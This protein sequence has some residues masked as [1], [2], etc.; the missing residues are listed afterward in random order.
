MKPEMTLVLRE[1]FFSGVLFLKVRK[2]V[3]CSP[4]KMGKDQNSVLMNSVKK[5][6]E[7]EKENDQEDKDSAFCL[8]SFWVRGL[9][10]DSEMII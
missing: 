5:K 1:K 3:I 2:R 8:Y 4:L 9:R 6:I 7:K 10:I